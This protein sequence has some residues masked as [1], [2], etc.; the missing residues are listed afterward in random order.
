MRNFASLL[1]VLLGF[2]LNLGLSTGA[3]AQASH[4]A[5]TQ[6][7]VG[8]LPSDYCLMKEGKMMLVQQGPLVT[9]MTANMTMR[10]GSMCLTDGT[11]KRPDGT[12]IKIKEGECMLMDGRMTMHPGA[13][14]RPPMK[15][16]KPEKKRR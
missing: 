14:Q 11:C 12:L 3:Y 13:G 1:P 7:V 6:P 4:Q 2:G 5:A 8:T 15:A 9:P 16:A 10:D